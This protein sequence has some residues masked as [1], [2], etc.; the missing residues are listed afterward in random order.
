MVNIDDFLADHRQRQAEKVNENKQPSQKIIEQVKLFPLQA[1]KDYKVEYLYETENNLVNLK[2]KDN[3]NLEHYEI[4]SFQK[5][6]ERAKKEKVDVSI[7]KIQ[8]SID[9]TFSTYKEKIKARLITP[10]FANPSY[11]KKFDNT[12]QNI[13]LKVNE[14]LEKKEICISHIKSQA[15]DFKIR[16]P[17][18]K[19][20]ITEIS[21]K[22]MNNFCE[23]YHLQ[24][25]S[26]RCIV[27]WGL[28]VKDVLVGA[29][30]LG[31]HP[32]RKEIILDRLCFI[33]EMQIIGGS[34]KLFTK[35]ATWAKE[36]G[37]ADV[38]SFSDNR[39]A[40]GKV[41][42]KLGFILDE[43]MKSDYFYLDMKDL[44][45]TYSKQSQK[46]DSCDCP[47]FITEG[48]WARCRDLIPVF[49]CG[50]KRWRFIT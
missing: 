39:Y 36:N 6:L 38:F 11:Y 26:T 40:G 3:Y 1:F 34:Q 5:W 14:W 35:C 19:C 9:Q 22:Q 28:I 30:S 43:E 17:A 33:P 2:Y 31:G 12:T 23:Q 4:K 45:K 7:E 49:D 44:T 48:E 29:I 8:E 25:K 41:Y 47:K 16:Y 32:R 24:G 50:K 42:E 13:F 46:K 37:I 10:D 21:K 20:E 18:R 27:A 15:G